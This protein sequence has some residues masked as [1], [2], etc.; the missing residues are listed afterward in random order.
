[1]FRKP[2]F[3]AFAGIAALVSL[4]PLPAPA[5][6]RDVSRMNTSELLFRGY[7]AY[8]AGRF[9]EANPLFAEVAKELEK[10]DH[11]VD[12]PDRFL[13]VYGL[14][15]LGAGDVAGGIKTLDQYWRKYP[16]ANE[17][18][19]VGFAPGTA[20]LQTG[21]FEES[22]RVLSDFLTRFP[23]DPNADQARFLSAVAL[24]QADEFVDAAT[25]LK[26]LLGKL[27]PDI[28]SQATALYLQALLESENYEE[29]ETLVR[30]YDTDR[31]GVVRISAF[32]L[33]A[34]SLADHLLASGEPRRAL[35]VLQRIW[36]RNRLLYRQ[37]SVA[38]ELRTALEQAAKAD[39]RDPAVLAEKKRLERLSDEVSDDIATIEGA[40]DYDTALALR[41]ADA[42]VQL[43]RDR[44]AAILLANSVAR[45]P[46]SEVLT[47]AYYQL[48]NCYARMSSWAALYDAATAFIERFPENDIVPETL[49]LQAEAAAQLGQLD[50]AI[51]IYR[52]VAKDYPDGPLAARCH[53]LAAYTLMMLD[54]NEEAIALFDEHARLFPKSADDGQIVYWKGMALLYALSFEEARAQHA[55]YLEQFPDGPHA[56]DSQYRRAY[57]LFRLKDYPA[58]IEELKAFRATN[59][60]PQLA[61]ESNNLLG[62]A[63]LATAQ[64]QEALQVFPRTTRHDPAVY[65]YAVF[66]IGRTLRALENFDAA[67]DLYRQFIESRPDS[68]RVAEALGNLASLQRRDGDTEAAREMYWDAVTRYGTDPDKVGVEDLLEATAKLYASED[69][70]KKFQ[71][72]VQN[73]LAAARE[74]LSDTLQA[75]LSWIAWR[76]G[77]RD[78]EAD[79]AKNL[80]RIAAE[81]PFRSMPPVVL[82]DVAD[83]LRE[84][85]KT[86]RATEAYRTILSWWP[87][88]LQLDRAYASLGLLAAANGDDETALRYFDQ[89]ERTILT[90]ALLPQALNARAS[91]LMETNRRD[92]AL[93]TLERILELPEARGE[94]TVDA[95]IR[96]GD[97]HATAGNWKLAIP[98]Y[99]RV[100]VLYGRYGDQVAHAYAASARGFDALG[101]S[102]EANKTRSEFLEHSHLEDTP[103]YLEV[104]REMP[105]VPTSAE[106]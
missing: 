46:D 15:Q 51:G 79:A 50:Q 81:I 93:A 13:Y 60:Q 45:L 69:Q 48:L 33:L 49:Y 22:Q 61:D 30:S 85:G 72:R 100:Y 24:A 77:Q 52:R 67:A 103:E 14:S 65:D 101:R 94:P 56:S 34:S 57:C 80:D 18:A 28:D 68:P 11:K 64:A 84:T 6:E 41:E 9:A 26:P 73:E 43:G 12:R 92:E 36:S 38:E 3:V 31:P 20:L 55:L 53:F 10:P 95:L 66:R 89:F 90:S 39:I 71:L 16:T 54:R 98:Y 32:H 37:R 75:R 97:L 62:D 19:T 47:G 96:I 17:S 25:L 35:A 21:K 106:P 88:S 23:K 42:Y 86:E 76:V 78:P 70:L 58:A 29:A 27:R 40:T 4:A 99:Q 5:Q 2:S 102:E 104:R 59:P 105:D 63:Y 1:M 74:L 7:G 87:R 91:I 44:E 8:Q 83:R 82:A